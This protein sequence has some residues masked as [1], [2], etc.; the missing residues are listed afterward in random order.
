MVGEI[1]AGVK[2]QFD[3]G[4]QILAGLVVS[5][6]DVVAYAPVPGRAVDAGRVVPEGAH[7]RV[8]D[9]GAVLYCR[10]VV[11]SAE[12][13]AGRAGFCLAL[14]RHIR[15]VGNQ[16]IGDTPVLLAVLDEDR[17]AGV[18]VV[19]RCPGDGVVRDDAVRKDCR[20]RQNHATSRRVAIVR[21]GQATANHAVGDDAGGK[22]EV[23]A[24]SVFDAAVLKRDVFDE[25]VGIGD[26][27]DAKVVAV[28]ADR[29]VADNDILGSRAE[30]ADCERLVDVNL[31]AGFVNA[32]AKEKRKTVKNG[33]GLDGVLEFAVAF[34]GRVVGECSASDV[35]GGH[36][37]DGG[38]H[39]HIAVINHFRRFFFACVGGGDCHRIDAGDGVCVGDCRRRSRFVGAAVT[40][41]VGEDDILRRGRVVR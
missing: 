15:V 3:G 40:E 28:R 4:A 27:H 31:V 32:L 41:V 18:A 13:D 29:G 33:T 8:G 35:A 39:A 25:C 9:N 2:V 20:A 11:A 38:S 16:A 19:A 14:A 5:D 23:A 26:V 37:H 1:V 10:I 22:A 6:D 30:A 7:H 17:A 34:F 21:H 36:V 12:A 24:V